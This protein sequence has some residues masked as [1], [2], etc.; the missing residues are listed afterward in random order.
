MAEA[1]DLLLRGGVCATPM[2]V[3]RADVG[4]RKGQIAAIGELG[5]SSAAEEIDVAG[6][7]VLP[8]VIDSHVHFREPGAERVEDLSTGTAAAVLGGVTAVFDMPNTK[9]AT[10]SLQALAD[11]RRRAEGRI[12]CDIA[13]YAGATADNTEALPE[14]EH[15]PACAGIKIFM[16]SS[17]GG[18]LIADD[19]ALAKIL[20][21]GSR[22]CAVHCEDE[23]RLLERRNLAED[24][25]SV[26]AHA[27]WRDAETALRATR[28]LLRQ[29]RSAR[30]RVHI[31]HTTTAEEMELLAGHRDVASVEVTPQHL[32]FD[33]AHAYERLGNRAQVNPPIRSPRHRDALWAALRGGL[34]D[35]IG[36]DHAPHS[37]EEKA[38]PYP[39][40]PSGMPG[41]QTLVP[42][43]LTHV[44]KGR[45]TLERFVELT[46]SGP[47]RVFGIAGKGRLALGMDADFTIV[48]LAA[49][50][51]I[52][53][54]WIASRCG[55]TPFDGMEAVGW[56]L[57]TVIG[58]SVVMQEGEILGSPQGKM[59]RFQE[60]L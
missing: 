11:K 7:H 10:V 52:S 60:C 19:A 29:A 23:A 4:V 2:G 49:T 13:F 34:V 12:W 24:G 55:W 16:G 22:R 46:A 25:V 45:L 38:K 18:L 41:V 1:F 56:P 58:G 28:R 57:A 32:T 9:P 37:L 8:G 17:T 6:L 15:F 43:M 50:R 47:A 3:H 21:N 14:L 51:V 36:S 48:D 33:S 44:A 59:I 31:L 35:C 30:R 53:D 54:H 42:V 39:D 20:T 26:S 27:K 40:S 5:R